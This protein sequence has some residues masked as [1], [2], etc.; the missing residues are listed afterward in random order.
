MQ[1]PGA[2]GETAVLPLRGAPDAQRQDHTYAQASGRKGFLSAICYFLASLP[3]S[4]RQD[5]EATITPKVSH[6]SH[7]TPP[8][9]ASLPRDPASPAP[10]GSD[11]RGPGSR[12][13]PALVPT[14][15]ERQ[16]PELPAKRA[17]SITVWKF[18]VQRTRSEAPHPPPASRRLRHTSASVSAQPLSLTPPRRT[19]DQLSTQPRPQCHRGRRRTRLSASR[20]PRNVP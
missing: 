8:V 4:G 20:G 15:L 11:V 1:I 2:V 16:T 3:V 19:D 6:V 7:G 5:P 18:R 14:S 12:P 9:S 17:P 10:W 13:D